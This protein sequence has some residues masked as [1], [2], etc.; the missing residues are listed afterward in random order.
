MMTTA[1]TSQMIRFTMNILC[2]RELGKRGRPAHI[3]LIPHESNLGLVGQILC[4]LANGPSHCPSR[5]VRLGAQVRCE[6]PR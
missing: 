2:W 6:E 1:P 3:G 5:Y 4:A